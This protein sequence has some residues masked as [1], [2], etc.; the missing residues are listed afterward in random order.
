MPSSEPAAKKLENIPW[1]GRWLESGNAWRNYRRDE[2]PQNLVCGA[3]H[4]G[5]HFSGMNMRSQFKKL[6]VSIPILSKLLIE[7]KLLVKNM[8]FPGSMNYWEKRYAKG[9]TSGP[10]SYGRLSEFKAGILNSF[11]K[12]NGITSVIEFGCGDGNQLSLADYPQYI[13]LDVS[14]CAIIKCKE[15]FYQ[16]INKSFYLY[17]P[18]C[19]IDRNKLFAADLVLSVDVIY[20]LI[21]DDIFSMYMSH[22][23]SSSN[24]YVIIYSNDE[25]GPLKYHVRCRCFTG[26]VQNNFPDYELIEIIPNLYPDDGNDCGDTSFSSFYIYKKTNWIT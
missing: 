11:V 6:I 20:H 10:G 21:E 16:D 18:L 3:G 15:R 7:S 25:D 8:V 22:I 1:S 4:A 17:D 14:K 2:K 19:F 5:F 9:G 26:F 12:E 23:F 24:K 13:G